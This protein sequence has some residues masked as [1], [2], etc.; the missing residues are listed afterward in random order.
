MRSES[1]SFCLLLSSS[2]PINWLLIRERAT[3]I[4]P[5]FKTLGSKARLLG[6]LQL[7]P[8][9]GTEHFFSR[10]VNLLPATLQAQTAGGHGGRGLTADA[11]LS[12]LAGPWKAGKSLGSLWVTS[13]KLLVV[14]HGGKES[15]SLN[16]VDAGAAA[17]APGG[18]GRSLST[19]CATRLWA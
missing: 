5:E 10:R 19:A 9:P 4:R 6:Q 18:G 1:T 8:H 17:Q 3:G 7:H 16:H 12:D 11:C 14:S 15:L 2:F 13:K